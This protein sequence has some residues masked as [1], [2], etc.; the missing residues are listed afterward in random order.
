MGQGVRD[1]VTFFATH[2]QT[3]AVCVTT[4]LATRCGGL[5]FID[6]IS[7]FENE[8]RRTSISVRGGRVYPS[9]EDERL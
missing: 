9:E 5:G 1:L 8:Q 6:N 3:T 2:T 7:F 4:V